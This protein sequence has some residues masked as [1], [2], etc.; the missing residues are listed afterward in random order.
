MYS[1]YCKT[2]NLRLKK[3]LSWVWHN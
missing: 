1:K 2:A 3:D